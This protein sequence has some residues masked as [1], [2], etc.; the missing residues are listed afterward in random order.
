MPRDLSVDISVVSFNGMMLTAY[1]QFSQGDL[2]LG[3]STFQMDTCS[4][5]HM[6]SFTRV[7][8]SLL[9]YKGTTGVIAI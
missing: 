9:R 1:H 4:L 2:L 3:C 5:V 7:L 8:R 6:V